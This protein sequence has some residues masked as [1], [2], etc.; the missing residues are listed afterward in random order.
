[1]NK[2]KKYTTMEENAFTPKKV[3]NLAKNVYNDVCNL[4]PE[5]NRALTIATT[6]E[7]KKMKIY[8]F[9]ISSTE[10]YELKWGEFEGQDQKIGLHFF[11]KKIIQKAI[12]FYR[13]SGWTIKTIGKFS[14]ASGPSY[15][16]DLP[17]I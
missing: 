17:V 12:S 13:K 3:S 9:K 1:M 8:C 15:E 2:I 4:I 7:M 11:E 5:M 14:T 10:L 6:K 16:F